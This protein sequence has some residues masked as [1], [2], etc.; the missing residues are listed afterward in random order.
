[1]PIFQESVASV[2][3]LGKS[4]QSIIIPLFTSHDQ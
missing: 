1:M 4:S 3:S 2:V